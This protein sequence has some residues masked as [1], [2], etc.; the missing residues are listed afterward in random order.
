VGVGVDWKK[1]E[2]K[3]EKDTHIITQEAEETVIQK[4]Y[5]PICL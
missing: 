3:R 5:K 1:R 2:A 4:T